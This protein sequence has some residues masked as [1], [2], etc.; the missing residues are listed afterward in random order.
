MRK[1]IF[2]RFQ[3][4]FC[5]KM[6][7]AFVLKHEVLCLHFDLVQCLIQACAEVYVKQHLLTAM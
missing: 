4:Q 7:R 1:E 5:Q 6:P 3:V 2:A